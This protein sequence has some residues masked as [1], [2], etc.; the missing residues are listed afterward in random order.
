[1]NRAIVDDDAKTGIFLGKILT[2]IG[3]PLV[4]ESNQYGET[5]APLTLELNQDLG[6]TAQSYQ[7]CAVVVDSPL[8]VRCSGFR[9]GDNCAVA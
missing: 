9:E 2:E 4:L 5:Q 7:V 3:N 1:M 8:V 6:R